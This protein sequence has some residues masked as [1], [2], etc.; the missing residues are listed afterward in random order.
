MCVCV[1]VCVPFYVRSR[2]N[3]NRNCRIYAVIVRNYT[4]LN[5]NIV[6]AVVA[7]SARHRKSWCGYGSGFIIRF[8][9]ETPL[10]HRD[11]NTHTHA[12]NAHGIRLSLGK[13]A[14]QVNIGAYLPVPAVRAHIATNAWESMPFIHKCHQTYYTRFFAFMNDNTRYV[15]QRLSMHIYAQSRDILGGQYASLDKWVCR[16]VSAVTCATSVLCEQ[17]VVG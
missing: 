10:P 17:L 16:A 15:G 7:A 4:Q 9:C 5:K 8:V 2:L 3:R 11:A 1:P 6:V 13:C 14:R 12:Q